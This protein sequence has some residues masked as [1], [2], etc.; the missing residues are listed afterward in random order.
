[1]QLAGARQVG[2]ER[3]A[4]FSL[5][6]LAMQAAIDGTGI[7]LGRIALA[8]RDLA[9]GRLVRPFKTVLPL[10]VSYFLVRANGSQPRHEMQCFRDWLFAAG[11]RSWSARTLARQ[12]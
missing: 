5:A 10:D 8:E 7:V 9:A 12:A 11:K 4:K 1:L 2:S 3:G 6:E